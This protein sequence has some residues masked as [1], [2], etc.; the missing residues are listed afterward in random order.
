MQEYFE[1]FCKNI[2]ISIE[3]DIIQYNLISVIRLSELMFI[4]RDNCE[5]HFLEKKYVINEAD[6]LVF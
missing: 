2:N 4:V 5:K 3:K 6:F 1:S